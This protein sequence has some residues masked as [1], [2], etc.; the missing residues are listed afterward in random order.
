[1]QQNRIIIHTDFDYFYAQCE[2]RENPSLKDKPVVVCIYSGRGEDRGAVSTA[3]YIARKYGVKSGIPILQAKRK[4]KNVDAAFLP[5][6]FELYEKVSEN[7]MNILRSHAGKFEEAGIDEAFLD[8]TQRANGSYEKA[9]EF[10]QKIQTEILEKEKITVS[11]GVGPNKLV[12]KI[13]AGRQKPLGLTMVKQEDVESFLAPL[14]VNELLGVGKKTTEVM[15]E[16]GINTIDELAKFD[17]EKLIK[18][19]G[20]VIGTYFHNAANGIDF[21]PVQERGMAE[22]ISRMLTLKEDTRDMDALMEKAYKICDDI[23]SR[24]RE[25]NLDFKTVSIQLILQDMS[26]SSRAKTF[27]T[28]VENLD[29]LKNTAKEL[30]QKLLEETP[31]ELKARRLG[32]KISGFSVGRQAQRHITEFVED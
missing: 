24:A 30:F 11:M 7:I 29:V 17:L 9:K 19:F 31:E 21:S 10:A 12:A 16:M 5:A 23:Y 4:L 2:E 32:V 1:M 20:K 3:N 6:N 26:G 25:L 8:V 15:H 13:A 14:P 27:E 28:P 18:R 22:S